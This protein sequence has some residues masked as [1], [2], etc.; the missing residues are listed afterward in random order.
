MFSPLP[1]HCTHVILCKIT[2]K[3]L[4]LFFFTL[5]AALHFSKKYLLI[6]DIYYVVR[7]RLCVCNNKADRVLWWPEA[8]QG[9]S[10]QDPAARS[11]S[12]R[13]YWGSLRPNL[14][15]CAPSWGQEWAETQARTRTCNCGSGSRLVR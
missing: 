3:I 15:H 13:G 4:F 6:T 12:V 10:W 8:P 14:S 1:H 2:W 5:P 11:R 7:D 9:L